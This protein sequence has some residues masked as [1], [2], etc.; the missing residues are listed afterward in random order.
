MKIR[1]GI[2]A[3]LAGRYGTGGV[4]GICYECKC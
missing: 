1:K 2:S 3:V 4:A